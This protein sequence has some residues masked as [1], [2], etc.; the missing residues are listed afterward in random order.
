MGSELHYTATS[1]QLL[2]ILRT[3][4]AAK[5][6][7]AFR[8]V[9]GT[10]LSLYR[11]HR[12]SIDIDLFSDTSYDSIDFGAI[13]AFLYNTFSY[14]D[15]NDYKVVGLGKSYYVG[16]SEEDCVKLD[17]FYTDKFIQDIVLIDGI[18]LATVEEIIA[19]KIDVISRGGRKKDFWDIHE[20]KDDYSIE[21][22]L[23]LHK[24]RNPYTHDRDQIRRNFSNFENADGDFDPICLRGKY[25]E[26]VKL[27][28]IDFAQQSGID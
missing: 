14:V 21:E 22:M 13:Y 25:W 23:A 8:L 19:M 12:E 24:Q 26:I 16:N 3:L 2:N 28:I 10:A 11:G 7:S 9:G 20:L 5:E 27:D 4:M 15:T 18:R 17:L 6:L 1:K